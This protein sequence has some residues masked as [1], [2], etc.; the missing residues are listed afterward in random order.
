M[1]KYL[2]EKKNIIFGIYIILCELILCVRVFFLKDYEVERVSYGYEQEEGYALTKN[3]LIE[4][5][6]LAE[7]SQM[8][9]I[10]LFYFSNDNIYE[11][12]EL[13][14][15]LYLNDSVQ[16]SDTY[17]ILLSEQRNETQIFIPFEQ[18]DIKGNKIT[19]KIYGKNLSSDEEECP[20]IGFSKYT[21]TQAGVKVNGLKK[22]EYLT[23][24]AYYR[25]DA[26]NNL[27][28]YMQFFIAIG[29]GVLIYV[30]AITGKIE[31]KGLKRR[32]NSKLNKES[33]EKKDNLRLN[34]ILKSKKV[35]LGF[36]ILIVFMVVLLEYTYHFSVREYANEGKKIIV[37]QNDNKEEYFLLKKGDVLNQ[38]LIC[39]EENWGGV[40][41]IF[42]TL[43]KA[44]TGNI[45]LAV[46]EEGMNTPIFE[47][48]YSLSEIK[49]EEETGLV[50]EDY[51]YLEFPQILYQSKGRRYTLSFRLE[52]D[53]QGDIK[54][55]MSSK[56]GIAKASLNGGNQTFNLYLEGYYKTNLFLKRLFKVLSVF[57]L[58]F[59]MAIY[60]FC[61]VKK[62]KYDK[63]FL[64]VIG[65][66]GIIYCFI[67][68]MYTTPDEPSHIDTAYRVS[69]QIM[70]YK[71]TDSPYTMYKR[72]E[73]IDIEPQTEINTESYRYLYNNLFKR[74]NNNEL[75]EAFGRNNLNNATSVFYFPAALGITLG[76]ILGL[77][78]LP[79]LMLGRILN[80]LV[81][82]LL[83][84]WGIKQIPFG[85]VVLF[86]I[87]LLPI[88]LQ[89]I[90]SFSYDAIII[91]ISYVY[92]GYCLKW[93]Y[94]EKKIYITETIMMII[95]GYMIAT[96][97]G[98]VYLPL[99]FLYLLIPMKRG[100]IT[101]KGIIFWGSIILL[102]VSFFVEQNINVFTRLTSAQ[103]TVVGGASKEEL[104]SLAYFLKNPT[105]LIRIF[106]NTFYSQGDSLVHTT[107]GGRLG[108]L[109][110]QTQWILAIGFLFLMFLSGLKDKNEKQYIFA[111]DRI[112]MGLVS[113]GSFGLVM[114]SMLV[115]WTPFGSDEILGVQGRYFLP[116]LGLLILLFRNEQLIYRKK[117]NESIIFAGCILQMFAVSQI[118]LGIFL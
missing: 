35:I 80:L 17:N 70:G 109:S 107:L 63:L 38:S 13:V 23:M 81:T 2:V 102:T 1:R 89:Q 59:I 99:A 62:V 74:S 90:M 44:E 36:A 64:T 77:G 42:E 116:F 54:I 82:L 28:V 37:N 22:N 48:V 56:G 79:T 57:L 101:K 18:S 10:G 97:K 86:V 106:E 9:G 53:E 11:D 108:W 68:P 114:V 41:L 4:T 98:G 26:I 16:K 78:I 75:K 112:W 29:S 7:Y 39:S 30:L 67:I 96:C 55:L 115:A 47:N 12:E 61:F 65:C 66:L 94:T 110:V 84:Y 46:S 103:G 100:K 40:G 92:I 33:F 60:F 104:Y 113:M 34:V 85:K 8:S 72:G 5:Q 88:T 25:I 3:T 118:L 93:A 45:V 24:D 31:A 19:V 27:A 71:D 83:M 95:I 43:D 87:A 51:V 49:V 117:K 6:F 50:Q 52:N 91:G 76:R 73:D 32:K 15:D 69:N 105:E 14:V 21:K 20:S 111:K 58:G